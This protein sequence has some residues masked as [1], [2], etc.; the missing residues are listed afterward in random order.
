[1]VL[2]KLVEVPSIAPLFARGQ[3]HF[4]SAAQDWQVLAER[5]IAHRI[6]DKQRRKVLDQ[7][8]AAHGVR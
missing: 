6:F 2:H 8:A 1:M 3:G 5:F 7:I 4:H